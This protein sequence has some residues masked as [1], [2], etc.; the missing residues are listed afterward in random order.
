M[1]GGGGGRREGDIA[2]TTSADW[3]LHTE[4]YDKYQNF[5]VSQCSSYSHLCQNVSWTRSCVGR[6]EMFYLTTHSTHLIYGY[7]ASD[8]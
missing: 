5:L 8:I 6:N 4:I 7:M 3:H 2:K 1:G